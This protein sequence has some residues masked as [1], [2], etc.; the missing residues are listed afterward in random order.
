VALEIRVREMAAL[1]QISKTTDVGVIARTVQHQVQSQTATVKQVVTNPVGLVTGVPKGV[2]HLFKGYQAQATEV[3]DKLKEQSSGGEHGP[4]VRGAKAGA[5]HLA[6]RYADRYLGISAAERRDYQQL[7]VDPYSDN[8]VLRK[9]V[10]HLAQVEAATNV[11]LHFAGVPGLPYLG[12]VRRAMDAIYNED[13][14][15]LRA[16]RRGTL[17]SYG[18]SV[19]EIKQFENTLLLSPTR[20]ALLEEDAKALEGIAGRGELFRHAMS[21]TSADEVR[22]F[23]ASVHLLVASQTTSPAAEVLSGLRLPAARLR[24]GKIAVYGAFDAVRWT[25]EVSGYETALHAALPAN[26]GIEVWLSGSISDRA[27][28]ELQARGWQV[29]ANAG[30]APT[31][32]GASAGGDD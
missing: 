21:V 13:P 7:G 28:D 15:V 4:S 2:A 26:A 32:T 22:V 25:Q 8:A 27:R 10:H 18:L 3:G 17:A 24:D 20:Q 30:A 9:A 16:R 11:G 23:L 5:V 19:A 29:H 12:D 1:T 31:Q 6:D 14:A